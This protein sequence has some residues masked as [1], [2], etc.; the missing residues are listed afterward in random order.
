MEMTKKEIIRRAREDREGIM[1]EPRN[2]ACTYALEG[3]DG[4]EVTIRPLGWDD[5]LDLAYE[6][7][8]LESRVVHE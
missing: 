7:G 1:G 5:Y 6:A 3:A 4:E 2:A 8:L